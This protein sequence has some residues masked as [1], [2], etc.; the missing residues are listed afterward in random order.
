MWYIANST[1]ILATKWGFYGWGS[2]GVI[3]TV[4]T[5][6]CCFIGFAKV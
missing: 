4:A 1:K 3:L 2:S 5:G 6:S